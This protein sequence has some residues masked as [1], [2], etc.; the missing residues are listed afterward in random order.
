MSI[1]EWT[2]THFLVLTQTRNLEAIYLAVEIALR[3]QIFTLK[4]LSPL[5]GIRNS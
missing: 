2:H 5:E 4:Y 3:I 1:H